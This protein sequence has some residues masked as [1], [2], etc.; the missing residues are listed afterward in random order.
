MAKLIAQPPLREGLPFGAGTTVL[1]APGAGVITSLAPFDGAEA[2]LSGALKAAHG[3]AFPEPGRATGGDAAR[4]V[5]TGRGQAMLMGPAPGAGL[6]KHA[7]LTDQSDAWALFRLEGRDAAAV[8]ARLMPIDL[9]PAVFATGHSARTLLGHM[10]CS[11]T[12]AEEAGFDIMVMRSM[13]QS[14]LHELTAAMKSVAAQRGA[15]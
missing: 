14:A 5:W 4:C 12:R 10:A 9:R 3:L 11:V 15:G 8:L 2:A 1:R 13:A 6:A 7:A